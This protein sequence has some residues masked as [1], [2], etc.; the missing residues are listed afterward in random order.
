MKKILLSFVVFSLAAVANAGQRWSQ[1]PMVGGVEINKLCDAGSHFRTTRPVSVCTEWEGHVETGELYQGNEWTCV[2]KSR[3]NARISK[4][5]TERTCADRHV[6]HGSFEYNY[7]NVCKSFRKSTKRYGRTFEVPVME[8][9]GELGIV[10]VDTFSY[11][12]PSC[13]N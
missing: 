10:Q 3:K 9:R 8:D 2:S 11:R 4:V 6:D 1:Y 12:I 5:Y 13:N 7:P